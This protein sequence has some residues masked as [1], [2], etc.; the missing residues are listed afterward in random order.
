MS[1]RKVRKSRIPDIQYYVVE[2]ESWDWGFSFGI[3]T[4]KHFPGPFSDYRHLEIRGRILR[5]KRLKPEEASLTFLPSAS[6]NPD[7]QVLHNPP[8]VGTLNIYGGLLQGLVSMPA[9]ALTQILLMLTAKHF[10][11]VVLNGTGMRYRQAQIHH[12]RLDSK[13]DNDDLP[14]DA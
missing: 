4:S 7:A 13:F 12:Y 6:Y 10:K 2:I 9:D 11:Y 1:R 8:Q 14:A 3:E 5:P